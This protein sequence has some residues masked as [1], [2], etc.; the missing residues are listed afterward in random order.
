LLGFLNVYYYIKSSNV[1]QYLFEK[2]FMNIF[3]VSNFLILRLFFGT[4]KN[5]KI[6]APIR[7]IYTLCRFVLVAV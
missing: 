1:I 3:D 7:F 2:K 6:F 5:L 4:Y